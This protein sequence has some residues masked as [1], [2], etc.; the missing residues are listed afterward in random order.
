MCAYVRSWLTPVFVCVCMLVRVHVCV[1]NCHISGLSARMHEG[2]VMMGHKEY[3]ASA[4][5]KCNSCQ[6]ISNSAD[7]HADFAVVFKANVQFYIVST[8]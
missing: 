2:C 4:W 3:L 6:L 5:K 8:S 7:M 1:R